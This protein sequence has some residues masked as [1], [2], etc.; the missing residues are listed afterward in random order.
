MSP[1][2]RDW[3]ED[4]PKVRFDEEN[5]WWKLVKALTAAAV[6]W[7]RGK[8]FVEL[9]DCIQAAMLSPP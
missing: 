9:I 5:R 6:E 8:F 3:D 1:I 7:G 2:I 4:M